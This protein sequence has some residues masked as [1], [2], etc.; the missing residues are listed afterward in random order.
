M[1]SDFTCACYNSRPT[2]RISCLECQFASYQYDSDIPINV[3]NILILYKATIIESV[4]VH[5]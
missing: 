1:K 4:L 3:T 2:S 5:I